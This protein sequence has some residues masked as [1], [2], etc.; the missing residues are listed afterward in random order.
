MIQQPFDEFILLYVEAAVHRRE[1]TLYT[2]VWY[3]MTYVPF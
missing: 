2:N 1:S 3:S